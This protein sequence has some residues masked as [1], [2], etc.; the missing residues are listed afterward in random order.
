MVLY[1]TEIQLGLSTNN[2]AQ[3][4]AKEG[5]GTFVNLLSNSA[6]F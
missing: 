2:L 1:L 4:L 5:T 3:D 6:Q